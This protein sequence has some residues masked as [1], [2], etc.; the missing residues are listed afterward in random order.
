MANRRENDGSSHRFLLLGFQNHCGCSHEIRRGL[1]LSRKAMT[2]L[3]SVLKSRDIIMLT[4]V[5]IVMAMVFPV[6]TCSCDRG[7]VKKAEHQKIDAF[8]LWCWRRL[9]KVPWTS[10]RLNKSI[11]RVINPDYSLEG[12]MLNLKLQYFG[13]QM[14]TDNSLEKYLILGKTE[15]RGEEGIRGWDGWMA[16][17]MQWTW[18]WANSRR[19]WGTERSGVLQSMGSQRVR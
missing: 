19:W 9:L 4:K 10:R 15:G 7:T 16:S 11:L 3:D 2:N 5:R 6:V 13:H 14:P 18:T 17:P 12:L 8:E 1:L